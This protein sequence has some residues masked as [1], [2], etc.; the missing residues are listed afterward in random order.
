MYNAVYQVYYPNTPNH[1]FSF[2]YTMYR[3]F[4]SIREAFR[5]PAFRALTYLTASILGAGTL[6]YHGIEGL[7]WLDALYLSVVTLTTVGYGDFSPHTDMGKIFTMM[8]IFVGIGT[9]LGFIEIVTHHT[10]SAHNPA[11]PEMLRQRKDGIVDNVEKKEEE[12]V[13]Q[14]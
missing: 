3:F 10:F 14:A 13:A 9:M 4:L 1:M 7:R 2:L 8:Y 6:F 11:I 12:M 5:E